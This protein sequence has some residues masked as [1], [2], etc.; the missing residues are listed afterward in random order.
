MVTTAQARTFNE[1]REA[2]V[3]VLSPDEAMT[4]RTLAKVL[5]QRSP[6]LARNFSEDGLYSRVCKAVKLY[7]D[8]FYVD[9]STGKVSLTLTRKRMEQVRRG[10]IVRPRQPGTTACGRTAELME[11]REA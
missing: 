2:M 11:A 7:E 4:R 10:V 5:R 1:I 8:A 9:P 6:H 3:A